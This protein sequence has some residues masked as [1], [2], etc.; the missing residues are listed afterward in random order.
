MAS[1][2]PKQL[3]ALRNLI[4]EADLL[5]TTSPLS[6]N[7]SGRAHE[8]LTA[9]LA[10]VD[11]LGRGAKNPAAALGAKGGNATAQKLWFGALPPAWS[12]VED[13]GWRKTPQKHPVGPKHHIH[14]PTHFTTCI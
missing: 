12:E 11:D 13:S 9:A 6:E 1:R 3:G 4:S 5:L 14:P 2:P 8:L 7:R 10:L